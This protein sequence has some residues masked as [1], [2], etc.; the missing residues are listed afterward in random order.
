MGISKS[1]ALL[2]D[3]RLGNVGGV[4]ADEVHELEHDLLATHNRSLGPGLVGLGSRCDGVVEL[5]LGGLGNTGK[6][7]LG[8]LGG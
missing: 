8:G 6:E 5:A 1:L 2:E 4:L 3:D 7:S